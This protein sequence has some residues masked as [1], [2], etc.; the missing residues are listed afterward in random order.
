MLFAILAIVLFAVAI[1]V[2]VRAPRGGKSCGKRGRRGCV[3]ATGPGCS[4]V[5]GEFIRPFTFTGIGL[6]IVQPG[7]SLVFPDATVPPVGV[8]Y[9]DDTGGVGLL[10]PG[11][12]YS[13]SW[14]LNPSTGAAVNLLVNGQ[15][16]LS[17]SSPIQYAYAESLT[18]GVLDATYFV[19]APLEQDNL[20]SL[21][22][23]GDSLLTLGSIPNTAV[24]STA[25]L[26]HVRVQRIGP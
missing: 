9:V 10:V 19:T 20:I 17:D 1:W 5:Y 21:V 11:G 8:T 13:V 4:P 12:T 16:P 3:G 7:G 2:V 26:T 22:N 23:V 24:G 6:P 15:D 14:V 25:I 18:T